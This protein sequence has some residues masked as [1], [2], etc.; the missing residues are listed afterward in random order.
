MLCWLV[1]VQMLL[2]HVVDRIGGV[3]RLLFLSSHHSK[4]FVDTTISCRGVYI[5]CIDNDLLQWPA[6][7]MPTPLQGLSDNV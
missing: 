2:E 5:L 4:G 3:T 1:A 6:Q 7:T